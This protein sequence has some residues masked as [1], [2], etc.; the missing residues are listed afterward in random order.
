[1]ESS[2][3]ATARP[4]QLEFLNDEREGVV[5]WVVDQKAMENILLHTFGLVAGRD[6]GAGGA[7]DNV[8]FL[9]SSSLRV[10]DAVRLDVVDDGAPLAFHVDGPKRT[11][12]VGG[13]RAEVRLVVQL[14]QSVDRILSVG[15]FVL[16]ESHDGL[17]VVVQGLLDF[18]LG[19]FRIFQTPGLG[20]V[21]GTVW[22][23]NVLVSGLGTVCRLLIVG[24]RIGENS[25]HHQRCKNLRKTNLKCDK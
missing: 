15:Q 24:I 22:N 7:D 9:N 2:Y 25:N 6:Q 5:V 13:T 3:D 21:F 19:I 1:M 14:V 12:V 16:V 20:R 18:V 10:L 11:D 23:L 17:V 4:R 8:A